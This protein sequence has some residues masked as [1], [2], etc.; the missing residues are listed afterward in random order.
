MTPATL[1]F[2]W[3]LLAGAADGELANRVG[4]RAAD[5]RADSCH[6]RVF[7]GPDADA[8]QIWE[9]YEK[10]RA[11]RR[12]NKDGSVPTR[13]DLPEWYRRWAGNQLIE[14]LNAAIDR[15]PK[16]EIELRALI[17]AKAPQIEQLRRKERAQREGRERFRIVTHEGKTE[18]PHPVDPKLTDL[19]SRLK[20]TEA[21]SQEWVSE[22]ELNK[23][24]RREMVDQIAGIQEQLT[25]NTFQPG[26]R[27]GEGER[28]GATELSSIRAE[29]IRE[30]HRVEKAIQ[31]IPKNQ[32]LKKDLIEL[33][34]QLESLDVYGDLDGE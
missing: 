7:A 28:G 20:A 33:K 29:L 13:S 21:Q 12:A 8:P 26:K 32:E 6:L 14:K 9:L 34:L 15:V 16:R 27:A 4:S 2:A 18:E 1:L 11:R 19:Q 17:A 24:S 31:A 30:I 3:T 25:R 23:R 5:S 22:I 10:N